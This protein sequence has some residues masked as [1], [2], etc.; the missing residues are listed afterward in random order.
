VYK[1]TMASSRPLRIP[2]PSAKLSSEN[3]GSLQLSSHRHAVANA[4]KAQGKEKPSDKLPEETSS[5]DVVAST[6]VPDGGDASDPEPRS[7][8]DS[9]VPN[10]KKRPI[11]LSEDD[12]SDDTSPT[13]AQQPDSSRPKK[14]KNKKRTSTGL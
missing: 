9:T 1:Q 5:H 7:T 10:P 6:A 11:V 14:K 4:R 2:Q 8:S 13:P 12:D 3:A